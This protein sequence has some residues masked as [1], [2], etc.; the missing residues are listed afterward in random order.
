MKKNGF[1]KI[2]CISTSVLLVCILLLGTLL[3]RS[4]N[5]PQTHQGSSSATKNGGQSVA[6]SD[7]GGNTFNS[8]KTGLKGDTYTYAAV[9]SY[10]EEAEYDVAAENGGNGSGSKEDVS[11]GNGLI[12]LEKL[13]YRCNMNM[14]TMEFDATVNQFQTLVTSYGGFIQQQTYSDGGSSSIYYQKNE[15]RRQNYSATVRI[16][17]EHFDEFVNQL[18]DLGMIRSKNTNVENVSQEYSDLST[19]LEIYQADY[20]YYLK[21]I[22]DS[23]D[24]AIMLMY[25]DKLTEIKKEI[26][27]IKTRMNHIDSDVAYSYVTLSVHEVLEYVEEPEPVVEPKTFGDRIA[28]TVKDSIQSFLTFLEDLL[29]VFIWLAPYMALLVIVIFACAL[30]IRLMVRLHRKKAE[31]KPAVNE[32]KANAPEKTS[33]EK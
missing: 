8:A 30:I 31:K 9:D 1:W 17:S 10:K 18:G 26:E 22:A 23:G 16:P 15:I 21:L 2:L 33:D 27:R 3:Y 12:D 4:T 13:I 20:D 19:S 24:E 11:S 32:A 25:H 6:L 29:V 14:D 28:K 5:K 7:L